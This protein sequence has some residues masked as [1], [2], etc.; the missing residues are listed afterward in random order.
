MANPYSSPSATAA[1]RGRTPVIRP[2][3]WTALIPQLAALALMTGAAS[4]ISKS[5][6]GLIYGVVAY[7]AYS[8][9]TR[10]L[11]PRAHRRG[12][13]LVRRRQFEQAASAFQESYDFFTRNLWLDRYRAIIMLSASG[14]TYREMA[15]CNMAFCFSQIGEGAKAKEH[16]RRVLAEFPNNGL[17][18]TT[19]RMIESAEQ[20][21]RSAA[22]GPK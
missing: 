2:I 8:W 10:L 3:S 6:N 7:L 20:S 9:G 18:Q 19:L 13:R 16:Y 11:I 1:S 22:D 15:L 17:A 14:M 4:L 12:L 5:S 21:V